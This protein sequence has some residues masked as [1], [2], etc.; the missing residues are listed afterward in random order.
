MSNKQ[1]ESGE[2]TPEETTADL[3]SAKVKLLSG[4]GGGLDSRNLTFP[5]FT[6]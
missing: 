5:D 2:E 4:Q 1:L 3:D 6:P